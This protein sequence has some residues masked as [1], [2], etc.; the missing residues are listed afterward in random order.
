[1]DSVGSGH[2]DD[3]V[4]QCD[5]VGELENR[6]FALAVAVTAQRAGAAPGPA[7]AVCRTREADP[8]QVG[9]Q[10]RGVAVLVMAMPRKWASSLLMKKRSAR[11]PT[12]GSVVQCLT[13][14][15]RKEFISYCAYIE[16]CVGR[17]D[18]LDLQSETASQ[19]KRRSVRREDRHRE[20]TICSGW[21]RRR[22]GHHP[23]LWL[24]VDPPRDDRVPAICRLATRRRSAWWPIT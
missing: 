4:R 24:S 17:S 14:M 9:A 21:N 1:M 8:S 19:E 22:A 7:R 10:R 15:C 11:P 6:V 13:T 16:A 2:T 3:H 12:Q 23:S 5:A 20:A 18:S